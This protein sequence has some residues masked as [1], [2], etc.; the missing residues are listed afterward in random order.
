MALPALT[1]EQRAEAL[2]KAK[3]ARAER[4]ACIA[5]LKDGKLKVSKAIELGKSDKALGKVK[6]EQ[7]IRT[8]P[9]FGKAR[10]LEL[11]EALGIADNR[12]IAGLGVHQA[13]ALAKRFG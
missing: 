4:A 8:Q 12:R 2:E 5:K 13:E 3:K 6:V 9:G 1:E 7:L 10:A 11:M